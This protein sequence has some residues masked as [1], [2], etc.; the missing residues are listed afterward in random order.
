MRSSKGGTGRDENSL[1]AVSE[2]D[3]DLSRMM[4]LRNLE[5]LRMSMSYVTGNHATMARTSTNKK[6]IVFEDR[7]QMLALMER[8]ERT[9][10]SS[11][12]NDSFGVGFGLKTPNRQSK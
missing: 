10:R 12:I 2:D 3:R 7:E 9:S 6:T 4:T 1:V 8:E 5:Q 11:S